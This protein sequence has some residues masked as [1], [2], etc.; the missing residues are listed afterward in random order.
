M[1]EEPSEQTNGMGDIIGTACFT[2]TVHAEL[3]IAQIQ[4]P[5]TQRS[6][7]H[8]ANGAATAGVITNHK[9]LER[10]VLTSLLGGLACNLLKEND[11]RGICCIA[12]VGV[13]LNH[14]ALVHLRLVVRLVLARIVGVD[15]VSHVSGD[16]E[17]G[18][19]SLLIGS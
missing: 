13:N 1:L 8:R 12:S 6:R 4:C 16:K 11:S 15:R 5:R 18:G 10:N 19:Q 17:G 14:R 3:G 2:D 9:E 7:Q